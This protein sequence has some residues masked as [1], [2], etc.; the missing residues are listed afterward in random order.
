M[1]SI[2]RRFHLMGGELIYFKK[3]DKYNGIFIIFIFIALFLSIIF[4]AHNSSFRTTNSLRY[5]N[6]SLIV[7]TGVYNIDKLSYKQLTTS[8]IEK[9]GYTIY[10]A[11]GKY[12]ASGGTDETYSWITISLSSSTTEY[13]GDE[14]L[15]FQI[16]NK[17][18]DS[19]STS[20]PKFKAS[21]S[22][23]NFKYYDVTAEILGSK[24][25]VNWESLES[26]KLSESKTSITT[27]YGSGTTAFID[28]RYGKVRFNVRPKEFDITFKL[29]KNKS[30]RNTYTIPIQKTDYY[31][32]S[33]A[34]VDLDNYLIELNDKQETDDGEFSIVGYHQDN[35]NCWWDGNFSQCR[36]TI[37]VYSDEPVYYANFVPNTYTIVYHGNGNT[38]GSTASS[39]HTYDTAK[40]LTS[41]GFTKTGYRFIGWSTS[42]NGSV[43]YSDGQ[44]V[45][46]L[47]ATDGGTVNLYAKWELIDYNISYTLNGGNYGTYHPT[48]ATY[49]SVVNISNATREGYTFDGWSASGL[50]K[51]AMT[52]TSSSLSYLSTWDGNLTKN[53]YFANLT[54]TNNGNVSLTANWTTNQLIATLKY[55]NGTSDGRASAKYVSSATKLG[56]PELSRTGYEFKGWSLTPNDTGVYYDADTNWNNVSVSIDNKDV[57][58]S[59]VNVGDIYFNLYAIWVANEYKI[60]YNLAGG[61][62]GSS[63]PTTA[64]Y[65]VVINISNPTKKGYTFT[66]WTASGLSNTAQAGGA[67]WNGTATT[68]TTFK[69]LTAEDGG[70]VTL[71]ANWTANT[72]TINYSLGGDTS[73]PANLDSNAPKSA[74]Y[75]V[76]IEISTPTRVGYV[77]V[78]WTLSGDDI[79]DDISTDISTAQ[80]G[81]STTNLST[82]DGGANRN[83]YFKN[84]TPDASGSVTMTATWQETIA[85]SNTITATMPAKDSNNEYYLINNINNLAW[86][87]LQ[88]DKANVTGKFR[89]TNNITIPNNILWLPI[90]R[91]GSFSGTYDGQGYTI[92]GL[93]TYNGTDAN[94]ETNGNYLETNGGLF[95]NASG[96][97]ITN[98][99]IEDAEIYGQNAG[100]IAGSGNEGTKISNC[101]VSGSVNGSSI[102]S[103]IGNGNGASIITACLAK[104]VNT[105]SF[106]GG[107]ASITGGSENVDS[108]IY[109]LNDPSK[110]RGRSSTFT[111]YSEWIYPSNFAYPMPKA[112][113]WY[114]GAELSED[115]LNKWLGL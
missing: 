86:L 58:I 57:C 76:A 79:S 115:S 93:R 47:T 104:G 38:G 94:L 99:I 33:L 7:S 61:S 98:V 9:E 90:G 25:G 80:S 109:E 30:T 88:G 87:A 26:E 21:V 10:G 54:T 102:G 83:R 92:S 23:F 20:P 68:E 50:S 111:K 84:L 41:N 72:Y 40:A 56:L 43:V 82:W 59:D 48:T 24:N 46:N 28:K 73:Y 101:V 91:L 18:G 5:I 77:F 52:G 17:V 65:D 112:F 106:D 103:I 22:G 105:A 13:E 31:G 60:N 55:L 37:F 63:H 110:T 4:F 66:G 107:S 85:S 100:I 39:S 2:H 27:I 113:M 36:S 89:Q 95:A 42:A 32:E 3:H 114:P 49:N 11:N 51:T 70:T 75:N 69:N 64:T 78:G 71:T 44:N 16:N 96:A 6:M 12:S 14:R 1:F 67:S 8:S 19:Y 53:T 34:Y 81:A 108:C 74:T 45:T 15:G 97:T 29:T 62:H 35:P